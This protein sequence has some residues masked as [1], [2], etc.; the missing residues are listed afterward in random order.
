MPRPTRH[1]VACLAAVA[2]LATVRPASADWSF[3]RGAA[4]A[5]GSSQAAAAAFGTAP[6]AGFGGMGGAG[7]G[8][9][10]DQASRPIDA[11][12]FDFGSSAILH[13]ATLNATICVADN[14]CRGAST[15][16]GPDTVIARWLAEGNA[17]TVA[18]AASLEDAALGD[19]PAAAAWELVAADAAGPTRG[20]VAK[21]SSW[22]LGSAY[23]AVYGGSLASANSI[24]DHFSLKALNG[25]ACG[26]DISSCSSARTPEPGSLALALVALL[27][28]ALAI[29]V[30][31]RGSSRWRWPPTAGR[32]R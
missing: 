20:A 2:T 28:A 14:P 30:R 15:A 5:A 11:A 3:D 10:G 6:I 26:E 31:P 22:W 21:T 13:A 29:R 1:L 4:G 7:G 32:S 23:N 9:T 25:F 27:G 19:A 24:G 8:G 17:P 12:T 16:S 18:P